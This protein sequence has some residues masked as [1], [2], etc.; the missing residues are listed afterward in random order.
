MSFIPVSIVRVHIQQ[1]TTLALAERTQ[2]SY[3]RGWTMF[4]GFAQQYHVD[5]ASIKE[6]NLLEFILFLSLS[7]FAASTVQLYL[8]GVRHHLKL[9]GQNCFNNSFIIRMV[10]KR[11]STRFPKPDVHLPI[12]LELLADMWDVLPYVVHD[13][14]QITMFRCMLTL[15]YHSLLRPGE[16][17]YSPHVVTVENVY[18]V[19]QH[20]HIYLTSS[21]TQKEPYPQR[22]I[23][24]PQ[25]SRC[26]VQDCVIICKCGHGYL[27]HFSAKKQAYQYTTMSCIQLSTA[28]Q[29][30]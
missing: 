9:R 30:S 17:T 20:V 5:L 4:L 19:K 25:Q 10:V 26:P 18:F 6:Y 3:A 28:W 21:K 16:I 12:M 23:V 24:A 1:L 2:K 29:I 7:S 11:V 15:G 22:V 27:G 14:F 8:A 13:R